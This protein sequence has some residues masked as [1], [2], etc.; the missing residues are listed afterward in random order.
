M[1]KTKRHLNKSRSVTMSFTSIDSPDRKEMKKIEEE[2]G[3]DI[4]NFYFDDEDN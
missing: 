4:K 3:I 1:L 2:F